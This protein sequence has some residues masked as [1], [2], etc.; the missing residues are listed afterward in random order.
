ME[1]KKPK[2]KYT[3]YDPHQEILDSEAE[4][5]ETPTYVTR[6]QQMPRSRRDYFSVE[7]EDLY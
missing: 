4:K 2:D 5:P 3:P 1:P 7:V 6:Y